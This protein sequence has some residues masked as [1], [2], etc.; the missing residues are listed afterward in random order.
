METHHHRSLLLLLVVFCVLVGLNLAAIDVWMFNSMGV[1]DLKKLTYNPP[2]KEN[3]VTTP[4][5]QSC[6]VSCLGYIQEVINSG[7]NQPTLAPT[8]T[9]KTPTSTRQE[10]FVPIGSGTNSTSDWD[11]VPGL[12]VIVDTAQYPRIS[13][14]YFEASAYVPSG[15]EIVYVRLFNVTDKHPVWFSELTFVNAST[16][17]QLSSDPI[18]LDAGNKAYKVQMKTQLQIPA[19]L[20]SSRIRIISQ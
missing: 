4:T 9:S 14:S 7:N 1:R 2:P 5:N 3:V 16:A 20:T 19:S 13:K 18:T 8:T 15:N 6:P 11:D 17:Q 12:Q 10:F